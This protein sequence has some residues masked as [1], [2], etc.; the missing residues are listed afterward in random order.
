MANL[1]RS[2]LTCGF[3]LSALLVACDVP[4]SSTGL[5]PDGPPKIQQVFM[6]EQA[7]DMTTGALV[8][9]TILAFGSHD[10][11][12][13]EKTHETMAAAPSDQTIR[14]V[15]DELLVGNSLE[16]IKCQART[17]SDGSSCVVPNGGWSRVP[18]G[19]TPDDIADC[20]APDDLLE[21]TCSGLHAVCL[22]SSG[23][24]CGV[25]DD[26]ENGSADAIRFIDGAVRVVCGGVDAPLNNE[27]SFWQPAGNQLI[28]AGGVPEGSLGPAVILVPV[29]GRG[30]PS[31]S[32]C[33]LVFA[34]DVTDKDGIKPC[35]SEGGNP[36]ADCNAGDL[37]RL[38]FKTQRLRITSSA[39]ENNA[40]GQSRTRAR[41]RVYWNTSL[42]P[43]SLAAGVTVTPALP[44]MYLSLDATSFGKQL[45]IEGCSAPVTTMNPTCTPVPFDAA[46]T[47]TVT[48]NNLTDTFGKAQTMAETIT[49]TTAN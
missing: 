22:N 24:P 29:E 37:T 8:T 18:L 33:Q 4:E 30:L 31:N 34:D 15:F 41:V 13:T 32:D 19:A 39:P 25:E 11:V 49:F 26:D 46:T 42:D 5:H 48:L 6:K 38:H 45:V 7:E 23:I 17:L 10:A 43:A 28:P 9:S 3:A 47:Y 40:T 2:T 20:S 36:D 21:D 27:M 12:A 14:V 16:E 1:T 35:A 44:N